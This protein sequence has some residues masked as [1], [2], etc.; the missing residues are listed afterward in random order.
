MKNALSIT[1]MV[2]IVLLMLQL[3]FRG[4]YFN[5]S[6]RS[7]YEGPWSCGNNE[8]LGPF[9]VS[10]HPA[11]EYD[12]EPFGSSAIRGFRI[13]LDFPVPL[14]SVAS[15]TNVT[16]H[17]V[18]APSKREYEKGKHPMTVLKATRQPGVSRHMYTVF[19]QPNNH[20]DERKYVRAGRYKLELDVECEGGTVALVSEVNLDYKKDVQIYSFPLIYTWQMLKQTR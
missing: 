4:C 2:A 6:N 20:L 16:A 19:L 12:R 5:T 13:A 14:S 17:Y 1:V 15:I 10:V 9:R 8:D 7:V 18:Y 11:Y 3:I